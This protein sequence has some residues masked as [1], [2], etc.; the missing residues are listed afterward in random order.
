MSES[1]EGEYINILGP[2]GEQF[3]LEVDKNVLVIGGGIGVAPLIYLSEYLKLNENRVK[4]LAGFESKKFNYI[5]DLYSILSPND[6][7]IFTDDGT[8]GNEGFPTDYME[9]MIN[10]YD[11]VYSCGP[12]I[13]MKKANKIAKDNNIK[14]YHSLEEIMGCGVGVCMGCAVDTV[15]GYKLVCKDGPIF[16]GKELKW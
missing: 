5:E 12:E 6:V 9:K 7:K 4:F 2:L 3:P 10:K 16:E 14:I 15:N 13:M 11:I 1:K 8:E